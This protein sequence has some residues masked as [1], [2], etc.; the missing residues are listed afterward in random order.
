MS[1]WDVLTGQNNY[2]NSSEFKN[3][4]DY[5]CSQLNVSEDNNTIPQKEV[6]LAEGLKLN[7]VNYKIIPRN[8]SNDQCLEN[9]FSTFGH[10]DESINSSYKTWFAED[11]FDSKNIFSN[12]SV[13]NLTI[14]NG[15]ATHINIEK[16]GNLKKI[17]VKKVI[18]AASS[19]NTPKILLNSGYKNKHLGQHLKQKKRFSSLPGRATLGASSQTGQARSA[20][21][22]LAGQSGC[23]MTLA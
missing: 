4:M 11:K 10:S 7:N 17:A 23:T 12:T 15:R 5:V 19:L 16:N 20:W 22:G 14:S 21:L 1:E 8:T 9:G 2:F 6:K 3:S 13:K 18:L